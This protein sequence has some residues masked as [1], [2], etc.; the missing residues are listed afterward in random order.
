MDFMV[1]YNPHKYNRNLQ[2]GFNALAD[3]AGSEAT[4]QSRKDQKH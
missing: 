3:V 4:E 1:T 2:V